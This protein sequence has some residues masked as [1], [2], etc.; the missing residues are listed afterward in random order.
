MEFP[1]SVKGVL[2][3]ARSNREKCPKCVGRAKSPKSRLSEEQKPLKLFPIDQ[4]AAIRLACGNR[5]AID[6]WAAMRLREP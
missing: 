3:A 4:I 1:I 6:R 2:P 5:R